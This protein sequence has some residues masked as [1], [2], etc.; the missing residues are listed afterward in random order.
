[1]I[2]I[3][4]IKLFLKPTT[5]YFYLIFA[6]LIKR[7]GRKLFPLRTRNTKRENFL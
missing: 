6:R 2:L 5:K 1:M 7:D 4:K 3:S